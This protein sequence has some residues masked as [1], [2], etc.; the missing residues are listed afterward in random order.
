MWLV[1]VSMDYRGPATTTTGP[2]EAWPVDA[3]P[4]G[5]PLHLPAS[6]LL[7]GD[8]CPTTAAPE[9]FDPP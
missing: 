8:A 5:L 9:T 1:A 3:A 2:E 6:D 4:T 7:L